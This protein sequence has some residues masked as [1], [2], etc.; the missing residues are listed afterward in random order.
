[1]QFRFYNNFLVGKGMKTLV[2]YY[3]PA[4]SILYA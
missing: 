4:T 3:F 1:L 2:M